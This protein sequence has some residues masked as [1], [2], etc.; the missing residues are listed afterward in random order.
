MPGVSAEREGFEPSVQLPVRRISSAVHSTTLPPLLRCGRRRIRTS[1]AEAADLQSVPFDRSGILPTY[2]VAAHTNTL[3]DCGC[4]DCSLFYKLQ[5][6]STIFIAVTAHSVPLLPR[7]PPLRSRACSKL[8]VVSKPKINGMSY[9]T[10][11][12]VIPCVTPEHT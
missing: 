5:I 4:K 12:S 3:R 10:F 8:L 7:L 6:K 9:L 11:N 1:E 2:V